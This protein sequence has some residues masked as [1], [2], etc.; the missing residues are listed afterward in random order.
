MLDGFV[1][2]PTSALRCILRHCDVL[3]VRLSPQDLRAL[4]RES[5]RIPRSLLRGQR[6]YLKLANFL[7]VEDSLQL[8]AGIFNLGLFTLPSHPDFLRDHHA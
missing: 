2:N 5:E 6:A 4:N 1:K 7:T 3:S 8:A